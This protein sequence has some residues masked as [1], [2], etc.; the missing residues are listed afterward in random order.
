MEGFWFVFFFF[1]G[2]IK[3]KQS[4]LC[5]F[6]CCAGM[7]CLGAIWKCE[8]WRSLLL[9]FVQ[10]CER[11]HPNLLQGSATLVTVLLLL[12]SWKPNTGGQ[13]TWAVVLALLLGPQEIL[14]VDPW[15][16]LEVEG[17]RRRGAVA[18][19]VQSGDAPVLGGQCR[20][21]WE[22]LSSSAESWRRRNVPWF[23]NSSERKDFQPVQ[24][25][26]FGLIQI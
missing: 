5:H 10:G 22:P 15:P 19:S 25:E 20:A 18:F 3:L 14:R 1:H 2:E 4:G 11:A 26:I 8:E 21:H 23:Y 13:E 17:Q 24:K 7:H 12:L 16:C 6:K 9:F